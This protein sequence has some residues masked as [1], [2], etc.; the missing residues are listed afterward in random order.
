MTTITAPAGLVPLQAPIPS[1]RPFDLLAAATLV[2]PTNQRWLGGGWTGGDTPG[3]AHT[4]DPCSSGTDRVKASAGDIPT[5]MEGT[6]NVYLTGFCTTQSVG[7]NP[8]FFTDRL[9]LAFQVY[10][11]AAVER[12]FATGDGHATLGPYLGDANM[13]IIGGGPMPALQALALLENE[14]AQAGGGIIHV[15]PA[16]ATILAAAYAIEAARGVMYT[17]LGTPV[18]VGAGYIGVAPDG[19][20][21]PGALEEWMFAS[22]P[23]QIYRGDIELVPDRYAEAIDR[24]MN[25]V[26]F[27][28]ERPYLFNW[29]ARTDPADDA[30][31]QAGALV[32]LDLC[33]CGNA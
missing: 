19:Q 16:T 30:H 33:S 32:D 17:R 24:S 28:A 22:G 4:H 8:T 6:F 27:V 23:L 5:Q 1:P 2:D 7:P 14:I 18:A 9:R 10:E 3:P 29:I 21:A 12:V 25:D 26:L 11:G 15:A 20:G 31:V 13:E